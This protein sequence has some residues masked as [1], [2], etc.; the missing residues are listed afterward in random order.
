[1]DQ[2][3][4]IILADLLVYGYAVSDRLFLTILR[5]KDN[6][7]NANDLHLHLNHRMTVKE[8]SSGDSWKFPGL[9]A[10]G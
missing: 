1:M 4:G 2:A 5:F 6:I 3:D 8:G 7:I 10:S 9:S